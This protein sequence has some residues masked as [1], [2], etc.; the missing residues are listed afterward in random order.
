[1]IDKIKC[2]KDNN[3]CFHL[4]DGSTIKREF[5][6]LTPNGSKM[7]GRWVFRD[8][9][10]NI[11]D[12]DQY[13]ND[14]ESKHNLD[15]YSLNFFLNKDLTFEQ[16]M[17]LTQEQSDI[18]LDE[19]TQLFNSSIKKMTDLAYEA[20]VDFDKHYNL[21]EKENLFWK[22]IVSQHPKPKSKNDQKSQL[23]FQGQSI[24]LKK[25]LYKDIQKILT[26]IS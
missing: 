4:P 12:F 3:E 7:N 11:I 1:M 8:I 18:L 23:H 26:S 9:N 6:T 21:T 13:I 24:L 16:I 5:E 2:T 10:D 19:T 14:L 20:G 25:R 17:H 15:I 22:E